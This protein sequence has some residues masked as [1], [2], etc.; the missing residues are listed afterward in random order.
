MAVKPEK[1]K[2]RLK[3]LFPKANLSQKRLDALVAKLAPKPADDADDSAVDSV[4]NDFND[5]MSFEDI[6]RE[7]DRVRTLEAKAKETSDPP[8]PGTPGGDPPSDPPKGD[9]TP[10][11]AKGMF[12]KLDTVTKELETL[13]TGKVTE[14]KKQTAAKL[15]ESSE[16]LKGLKPEIKQSWLS[17]IP[18]T[19]ETTEDEIKT[20][21]TALETE[22]TELKQSM[23]DSG[24]YSGPAPVGDP[25]TK[26]D[27][28]AVEAVVDS[29]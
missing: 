11:W 2:E 13:K 24:N 28:K 7:D 3:A 4:I 8:K 21:L 17:R 5:I 12:D 15:F 25:N 29:M 9:D 10:A 14:T 26:V 19:P 18:V 1:I 23:A 16:V 22:Y 6:A 27:D 20:H